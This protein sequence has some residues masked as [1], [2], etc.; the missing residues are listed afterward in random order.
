MTFD[1]VVVS[2]MDYDFR[3][4]KRCV[5]ATIQ[6]HAGPSILDLMHDDLERQVREDMARAAMK[7]LPSPLVRTHHGLGIDGLGIIDWGSLGKEHG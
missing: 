5:T 6:C 4:D 3:Q 1:D 2:G 7:C